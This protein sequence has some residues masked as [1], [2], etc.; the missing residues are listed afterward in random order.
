MARIQSLFKYHREVYVFVFFL[1]VTIVF[2]ALPSSVKIAPVKSLNRAVMSPVLW[3]SAHLTRIQSLEENLSALRAENARLSLELSRAEDLLVENARLEEL[4]AFSR[5]SAVH[6]L[7]A[8]VLS[9][10]LDEPVT[11]IVIDKGRVDGVTIDTPLMTPQ[12]LV[13]KV[14]EADHATSLGQLYTHPQFR[15]AA[16]VPECGE[17]GIV[18]SDGNELL[19]T[20]LSLNTRIIAGDRVVTSGL[21]GVY[22]AGIPIGLVMAIEEDE[23][24]IEKVARIEP[25]V[26]LSGLFEVTL[27]LDEA[28]VDSDTSSLRRGKGSLLWLWDQSAL[29]G[30]D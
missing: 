5:E 13:G 28:Y 10:S 11:A 21:G 27:L 7:P 18:R 14:V 16:V 22:P 2:I 6:F 4:L 12:G 15:A 17:M 9:I 3:A 23:V 8:L 20:G 30:T 19:M 24:G 29:Q 1:T 25:C 26:P